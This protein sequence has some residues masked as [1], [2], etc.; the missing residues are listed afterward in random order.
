MRRSRPY[1][2]DLPIVVEIA[3]G[4]VVLHPQ[5]DRVLLL[6]ER[7]E[8]RWTLPKGHV[9]P[10]ESL[11][12]CARRETREETGLAALV[13]LAGPHEIHYKFYDPGRRTNVYKVV[14]HFLMRSR[15]GEVTTEPIFDRY[16][17][18]SLSAA[19]RRVPYT[20]DRAVLG[21]ASRELR[22]GLRPRRARRAS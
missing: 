18:S 21:W 2:P 6:H 14:A 15:G 8:D 9:E 13:R 16:A 1:R 12:Q 7:A 20:N 17:W 5:S 4:A 10:G 3:A 19:T 11:E 22:K